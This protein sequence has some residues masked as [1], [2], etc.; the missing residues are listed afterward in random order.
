METISTYLTRSRPA[1][2]ADFTRSRQARWADFTR[3]RQAGQAKLV[4]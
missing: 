4:P 3:S 2:Q 1:R